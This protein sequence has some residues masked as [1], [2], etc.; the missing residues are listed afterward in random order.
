MATS[1]ERVRAWKVANLERWKQHQQNY[2]RKNRAT[3]RECDGQMPFPSPGAKFC[4][5]ECRSSARRRSLRE[6]RLKVKFNLS[7]ADY[8]GLLAQQNQVCAICRKSNNRNEALAVDH[9][10]N[11]GKVR[12]L[13]CA[14]CNYNILGHAED[15]PELL[16]RAASYLENGDVY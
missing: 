9:D 10:H 5:G 16:R 11:T 3:C 12:G 6:R 1:T 4:S 13:L 2:R 7:L 14:R 8:N 15:D